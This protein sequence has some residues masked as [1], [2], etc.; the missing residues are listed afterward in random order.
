M[1]TVLL[2]LSSFIFLSCTH[3]APQSSSVSH[4]EIANGILSGGG[5]EGISQSN[6]VITNTTDWQNLMDQMNNVNNV[7]HIFTETNIDFNTYEVIAV[8]DEV[9]PNGGWTTNISGITETATEI[10][11]TYSFLSSSGVAPCVITQPFHIVKIQKSNK[12]VNFSLNE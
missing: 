10:E 11:V 8:F 1:K 12:P 4:T 9:R 6:R 3:N 2:I 5:A 7:T